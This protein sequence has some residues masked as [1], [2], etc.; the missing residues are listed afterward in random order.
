M[1]F[2]REPSLEERLRRWLSSENIEMG[3]SGK[4]RNVLGGMEYARF[5]RDGATQCVFMRQFGSQSL[6]VEVPGAAHPENPA[7][8][9]P[10]TARHRDTRRNE[11]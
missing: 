2:V 5:T 1:T 3:A 8:T 11:D 6:G 4:Y 10:T 7:I 9:T